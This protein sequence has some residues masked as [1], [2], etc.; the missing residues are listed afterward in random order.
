MGASGAG[1]AGRG[2]S[3]ARSDRLDKNRCR[4]NIKINYCFFFQLYNLID[5]NRC[6][7]YIKRNYYFVSIII[8]IDE[9]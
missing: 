2:D 7:L 9:K 3:A 6:R 5:K 8:L 4:F 1:R